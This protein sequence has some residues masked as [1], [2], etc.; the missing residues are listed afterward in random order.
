MQLALERDWLSVSWKLLM[1]RGA[2]G[3]VFGILAMVWPL[4]TA[5]ALALL[6]GLWALTDGVSSIV[7][8]FQ[9]GATGRVWLVV[10]GVIALVAAF[11]AIFSPAVTAATL[12]WILGIWLVVRGLF[13]L[14]GAFSSGAQ[15]PRWLLVG[16]AV[17]SVVL[18][19]LFVT[20]PGA[21]A[22]GIAFLL[23]LVALAWGVVFLGLGFMLRSE[24]AHTAH[25]PAATA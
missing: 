7:Q 5:I 1:V 8:A 24:V 20:N 2:L 25:P 13:E 10:M 11:F 19:V 15:L 23:G 21:G 14:V 17:L 4:E 3:I 18:G 12:T 6:F 22:A 9:P 16:S